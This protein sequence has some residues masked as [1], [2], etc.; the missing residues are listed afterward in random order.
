MERKFIN[1]YAIAVGLF[2]LWMALRNQIWSNESLM[3]GDLGDDL[4]YG[5]VDFTSFTAQDCISYLLTLGIISIVDQRE[6]YIYVDGSY[7]IFLYL[8]IRY[9]L[10]W[11]Q[12]I[13]SSN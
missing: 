2:L 4:C 7:S 13:W 12:S 5:T 8:I 10:F 3:P 6:I 1:Y 9:I 11:E